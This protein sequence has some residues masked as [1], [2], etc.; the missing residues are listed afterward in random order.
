RTAGA[1]YKPKSFDDFDVLSDM[2]DD[3]YIEELERRQELRDRRRAD[4]GV[5]DQPGSAMS[6]AGE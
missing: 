3:D 2:I 1:H 6:S 5:S 4:A